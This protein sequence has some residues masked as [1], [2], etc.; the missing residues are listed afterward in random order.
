M[1]TDPF[2]A[3]D[4]ERVEALRKW[5]QQNGV[6][7]LIG[8]AAGLAIVLGWQVWS[9]Y[10][11]G[12][13][14]LASR[15]YDA[16]MQQKTTDPQAAFTAGLRLKTEFPHTVYAL[17]TALQLAQLAVQKN[18]FAQARSELEWVVTHATDDALRTIGRLR[19]ARLLIAEGQFDVAE[20]HLNQVKGFT[21]EQQALLGDLYRARKQ[22]DRAKVAYETALK[23]GAAADVI[24]LRLANL[25]LLE[26]PPLPAEPPQA[27]VDQS[28]VQPSVGSPPSAELPPPVE[29]PPPV[30]P[31]PSAELPS[32]ESL[33]PVESDIPTTP[34]SESSSSNPN[35]SSSP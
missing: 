24:Q 7:A 13:I 23:A 25:S 19:L 6:A 22:L 12:Q 2:I 27:L 21:A 26:N 10:N 34:S 29:S 15:A 14:E 20:S 9:H 8:I 5:W 16:L 33:H 28:P 11:T 3:E 32:V 1:Q 31:P 30:E 4:D 17:L 35:P 18:D